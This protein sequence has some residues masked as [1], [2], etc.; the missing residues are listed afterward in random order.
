MNSD[1]PAPR[2][3]R[4]KPLL[5]F[6]PLA[7]FLVVNTRWGI[8]PA[9]ATL[10]PLSVVALFLSWKLEG[11]VSRIAL[12]GTVAVILFGGLT[13]LL[14]DERFIKI[15]VTAINALLGGVLAVG[16]LRGKPLLKALLGE[17]LRLS[18]EGWR[19]LSLRFALFFFALA[20]LNE[21][22]RRV[23]STDAWVQFKVFGVLGATLVFTFLQAPLIQKHGLEE[24]E[25]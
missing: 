22:L 12:Y 19:R 24:R 4:W 23:L 20:A 11:R 6:G 21:V 7:A 9:T 15:K 5:D 16:L 10:V 18:D 13:L 25:G 1:A 17:G 14:Q 8:L 3:S 2:P